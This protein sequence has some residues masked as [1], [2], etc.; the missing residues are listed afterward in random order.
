VLFA[1]CLSDFSLTVSQGAPKNALALGV[2]VNQGGFHD[3]GCELL[4]SSDSSDPYSSERYIFLSDFNGRAAM[5]INGHDT[6]FTLVRSTESRKQPKKG[7]RSRY[8]YA[9]GP[10][11][12]EVDYIK[13]ISRR[14]WTLRSMTQS[15]HID[16]ALPRT[17]TH[18]ARHEQVRSAAVFGIDLF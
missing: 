14:L 11:T 18:L 13:K 4:L 6:Q 10:T 1:L 5:N 16:L 8:W 3:G 2:V 7:D 17:R 9:S 15:Q 12:V